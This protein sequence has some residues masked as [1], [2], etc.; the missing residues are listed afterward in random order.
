M[1][2]CSTCLRDPSLAMLTA[3]ARW[4]Q[5][6]PKLGGRSCRVGS[7]PKRGE[8]RRLDAMRWMDV[9]SLVLPCFWICSFRSFNIKEARLFGL[10]HTLCPDVFHE[11]G[12]NNNQSLVKLENLT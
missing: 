1:S 9:G 8:N 2:E 10:G 11:G 5:R 3:M 7:N 4:A 12:D 6:G